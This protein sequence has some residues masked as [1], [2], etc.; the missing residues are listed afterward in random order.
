[1]TKQEEILK[2]L[3]LVKDPEIPAVNIVE[4][5]IVRNVRQ[6]E[7]KTIVEITPTYSGCPAMKLIQDEILAALREKGFENVTIEVVYSPAWTTDWMSKETKE[8]LRQ[9]GIAPPVDNAGDALTMDY[10]KVSCPYCNSTDTQ[11]RSRFGSTACKSLYYCNSC[12]QP[13]EY[14][15]SF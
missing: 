2:Y 13:F 6:E 12:N 9:Y 10:E 14:F 15:K 4:L 11:M 7:D 8:K 1:M 3:S 5:G